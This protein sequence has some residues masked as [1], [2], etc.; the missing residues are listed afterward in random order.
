MSHYDLLFRAV[1]DTKE[2]TPFQ[3]NHSDIEN[4]IL[5]DHKIRKIV[6]TLFVLHDRVTPTYIINNRLVQLKDKIKKLNNP[7]NKSNSPSIILNIVLLQEIGTINCLCIAYIDDDMELYK[8]VIEDNYS[9]LKKYT[10]TRDEI[11]D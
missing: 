1:V 8:K 7:D 3:A 11:Y 5:I 9:D 6:K 10:Y 2:I 4:V